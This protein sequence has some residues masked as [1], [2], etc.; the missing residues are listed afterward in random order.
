M[1]NNFKEIVIIGFCCC[2]IGILAVLYFDRAEE[3]KKL[4]EELAL[5]IDTV[6]VEKE[7]ILLPDSIKKVILALNDR[8]II[9]KK[10]LRSAKDQA[11]QEN[12]KVIEL[13][14]KLKELK[15]LDLN[16]MNKEELLLLFDQLQDIID[17]TEISYLETEFSLKMEEFSGKLS[18]FSPLA[19]DSVAFRYK[20]NRNYVDSIFIM[21]QRSIKPEKYPT[22]KKVALWT[23]GA[24]FTGIITWLVK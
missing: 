16:S 2:I 20:M 6:I 1:K 21:G 12:K 23:S 10:S 5:K 14:K 13:E 3:N 4:R 22:W 19:V 9:M 15:K 17:P 11:I 18:A 24:I 7:V 8:V